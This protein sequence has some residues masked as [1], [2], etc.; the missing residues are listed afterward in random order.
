M[1]W[2]NYFLVGF[3]LRDEDNRLH[4]FIPADASISLRINNDVLIRRMVYDLFFQSNFT[5]EELEVLTF[6]GESTSLPSIGID[7]TKEIVLFYEDW[8]NKSVVGWLFHISDVDA[9]QKYNFENPSI[10]KSN[11]G[12]LGCALILSSAPSKDE[13]A[14]FVQYANDLLIPTKDLS[15]TKRFFSNDPKEAL[16]QCFFEGE[17]GGFL[18]K[19]GVNISF[20]D[21]ELMIT[22]KG[23][24][25]PLLDYAIDSLHY[26]KKP[27]E[28][29]YL[30]IKAGELPDTLQKYVNYFLENSN[31]KLPTITSQHVMIYG[32]EIDNL[33]GSLA[34]LPKFDAIFRFEQQFSFQEIL[35]NLTNINKNLIHQGKNSFS[36]G[37][38]NYY[39]KQ[40]SANE[41]YIGIHENPVILFE[42]NPNF[43]QLSGNL[44]SLFAIEGTGLIA[45]I[46]QLMPE[47]QNSKRFF[48]DVKEFDIKAFLSEDDKVIIKGTMTFPKDKMAS[49]E[50]F[51]YLIRF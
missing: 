27:S 26:I 38:V 5:N 14:L 25:N 12:N 42:S 47:V 33:K 29:N 40:I 13:T 43:F 10:I 19:T 48:G 11:S 50:F 6:K 46:A 39:I 1:L 28:M 18:Q 2:L 45:Q 24:K 22:G 34:I 31:L 4:H 20:K 16:M 15:Q 49:L 30:E 37:T 41:I 3:F 8:N 32:L 44:A 23:Q 17:K 35:N 21:E 9:F 51:N 7:I 36:M